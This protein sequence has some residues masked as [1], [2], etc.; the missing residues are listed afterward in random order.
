MGEWREPPLMSRYGSSLNRVG[1]GGWGYRYRYLTIVRHDWMTT[2]RRDPTHTSPHRRGCQEQVAGRVWDRERLAADGQEQASQ[3]PQPWEPWKS[4]Y[5]G[6]TDAI[7]QEV[8]G[9]SG[10]KKKSTCTAASRPLA[11]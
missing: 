2:A 8:P 3:G 11:S 6:S 5:S 1:S 10:I 9:G 7:T 4:L